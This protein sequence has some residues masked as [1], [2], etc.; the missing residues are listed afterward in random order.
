MFSLS[1]T[2][3][4]EYNTAQCQ[5]R[6]WFERQEWNKGY[7][8]NIPGERTSKR[9]GQETIYLF[10]RHTI[11]TTTI[12]DL[13]KLNCLSLP[14]ADTDKRENILFSE[15]LVIIE[16]ACICPNL[17]LKECFR[18]GEQRVASQRL[19]PILQSC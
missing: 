7:A 10:T 14:L 4:Y 13:M 8:A 9:M 1:L 2:V 6:F 18:L 19:Q 16:L 17:L 15:T 11:Y 5:I 3:F 12:H